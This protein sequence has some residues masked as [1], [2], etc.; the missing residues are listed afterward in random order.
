MK[1]WRQQ[2][3]YEGRS[4][5]GRAMALAHAMAQALDGRDAETIGGGA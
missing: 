3:V 5:E 1:I 4:R 2:E